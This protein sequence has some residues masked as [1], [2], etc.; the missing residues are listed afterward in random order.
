MTLDGCVQ[1]QRRVNN[2]SQQLGLAVSNV[3]WC[4]RPFLACVKMFEHRV[5]VDVCV[6]RFKNAQIVCE[7][8]V[9][10]DNVGDES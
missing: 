3:V 9:L 10:M 1:C 7:E 5:I 6:E 4:A 2:E 8:V